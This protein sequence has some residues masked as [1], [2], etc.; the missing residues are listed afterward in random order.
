MMASSD[1]SGAVFCLLRDLIHGRFGVYYASDR[2][3]I[4]ADRLQPL[5]AAYGAQS[6]LDY[7]YLLKEGDARA[8]RDVAAA[9]AVNETYFWREFDAI[10]VLVKTWVP[11]W[12]A[13]RAQRPVRI[14]S[15]G[16]ATG[17]EPYTI[18]IA[19][20]M[21]HRYLYGPIEIWAS[22]VNAEALARAREGRYRARSL[23]LLPPEVRKRYFE[24]E[25]E[26]WWRLRSMIRDRVNFQ[27]INLFD[28]NGLRGLPLFD[29]IF[30]RN[31]FIYFSEEAIA[32]V[33]EDMT[34]LLQPEGCLFLGAAESLFRIPHH[35]RLIDMGGA[36][37][38]QKRRP[39]KERRAAVENK[40]VAD[41]VD[42]RR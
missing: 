15:A 10:D 3:E 37:I 9:L 5:L 21:A 24:K 14:W 40:A 28:H 25:D 32:T 34:E 35:L 42:R 41:H 6:F 7:Y 12:Q 22:D 13:E 36:S 23:R 27:V 11:R 1:L 26:T 16:C 31:V 29:A 33:V 30:C 38:Y 20:D 19:L 8:W 17:E 2:C 39:L 4:L 18:A